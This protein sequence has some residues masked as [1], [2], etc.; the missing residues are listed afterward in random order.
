MQAL[1]LAPYLALLLCTSACLTR[2]AEPTAEE[3]A[4]AEYG[5]EPLEV[6]RRVQR[7]VRDEYQDAQVIEV[8]V[9]EPRKGWFGNLGGLVVPRDVRFGWVV[10]FRGYRI[11]FTGMQPAVV[12]EVFFRGDALEGV[13]DGRDGF[14]F[15]PPDR[16]W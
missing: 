5:Q 13:A 11:G 8:E 12:G 15:V 1:R 3:I 16:R 7:F 2:Q 14:R 4:A 10:R 9:G 6:K